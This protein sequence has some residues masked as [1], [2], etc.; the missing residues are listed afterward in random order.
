MNTGRARTTAAMATTGQRQEG[1]LERYLE[2][3]ARNQQRRNY[4]ELDN[5]EQDRKQRNAMDEQLF[6][7]SLPRVPAD[8]LRRLEDEIDRSCPMCFYSYDMGTSPNGSRFSAASTQRTNQRQNGGWWSSRRVI[9]YSLSVAFRSFICSI[10][11]RSTVQGK[12]ALKEAEGNIE[13]PVILPCNHIVGAT[14][15]SKWLENADTCPM[16]R[17]QLDIHSSLVLQRQSDTGSYFLILLQRL[18]LLISGLL[19]STAE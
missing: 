15:I 7:A 18:F 19:T 9:Y 16:C 2:D 13:T 10:D 8:Y 4:L 3:L 1:V 11:G 5:L 6:I 12:T 14:C 17:A